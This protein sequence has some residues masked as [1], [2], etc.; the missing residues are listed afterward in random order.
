MPVP[1]TQPLAV[2]ALLEVEERHA[3]F[4]DGVERPDPEELFLQCADEPLG[5]PVALGLAH[6]GRTGFDP[7]EL[8][9]ILEVVTHIL[10]AVIVARLQP[11]GDAVGVAAENR[12]YALP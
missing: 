2:V 1:F 11:R 7:E 12:P 10:A 9:L 3:Q 4:L 6:E 5:D 8:Q